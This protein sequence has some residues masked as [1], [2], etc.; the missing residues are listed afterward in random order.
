V[1]T[2]YKKQKQLV[3]CN[4][5]EAYIKCKETHRHTAISSSEF[6]EQSVRPKRRVLAG[7]HGTHTPQNMKLMMQVIGVYEWKK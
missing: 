6:S 1:E 7:A 5:K 4:L 2:E 3:Q